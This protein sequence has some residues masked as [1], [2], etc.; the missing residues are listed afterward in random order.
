MYVPVC[1]PSDIVIDFKNKQHH[2]LSWE[3]MRQ[4]EPAV[5]SF[6]FNSFYNKVENTI[7]N[8]QINCPDC[9]ILAS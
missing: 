9:F 5:Q 3:Q 1:I 4:L 2:Y 8:N 7:S 6:V